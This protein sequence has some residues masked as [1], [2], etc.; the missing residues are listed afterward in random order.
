[1]SHLSTPSSKRCQD[2]VCFF[3]KVSSALYNTASHMLALWHRETALGGC[4][5]RKWSCSHLLRGKLRPSKVSVPVVCRT[6]PG[7]SPRPPA[8]GEACVDS[9]WQ[10]RCSGLASPTE[11]GGYERM[12]SVE[13]GRGSGRGGGGMKSLRKEWALGTEWGLALFLATGLNLSEPCVIQ[14]ITTRLQRRL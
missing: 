13:S 3:K 12:G 6:S 14:Q 11:C 9:S 4:H 2:Y 8:H 1:M 5:C 7:P 10:R